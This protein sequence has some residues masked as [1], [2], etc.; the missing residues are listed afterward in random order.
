[1]AQSEEAEEAATAMHL[2][3]CWET[4][5]KMEEDESA[6]ERETGKMI[7]GVPPPLARS[8]SVSWSLSLS[9]RR[10][11]RRHAMQRYGGTMQQVARRRGK[12]ARGGQKFFL[13][14]LRA[15]IGGRGARMKNAD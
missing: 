8:R 9:E 14:V 5:G 12:A 13:T 2:V 10:S 3:E 7:S 4:R 11:E 6:G 1:M 15:L